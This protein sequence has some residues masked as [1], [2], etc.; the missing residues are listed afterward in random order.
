LTENVFKSISTNSNLNPKPN[1]NPNYNAQKRFQENEMT[2]FFAQVST[3]Q[4]LTFLH[5]HKMKTAQRQQ[6]CYSV[7]KSC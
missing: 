4:V 6:T 2:S 7:A 5:C 1:S 3:L